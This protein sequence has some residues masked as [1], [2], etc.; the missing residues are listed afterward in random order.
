M[1]G[2]FPDK[3]FL[4]NSL[5]KFH[6]PLHKPRKKFS[7][8]LRSTPSAQGGPDNI[9]DDPRRTL[10]LDCRIDFA[11]RLEFL[12]IL[13]CL[14]PE[15]GEARTAFRRPLLTGSYE[16]LLRTTLPAKLL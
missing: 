13:Y 5:C 14:V 6:F 8:F 9:H 16:F 4:D 2:A 11:T 3:K 10:F 7:V 12:K 1:R 15:V